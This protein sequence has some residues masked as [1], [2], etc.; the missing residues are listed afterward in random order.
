M[1]LEQKALAEEK[2]MARAESKFRRG[3]AIYEEGCDR[4]WQYSPEQLGWD[5]AQTMKQLKISFLAKAREDFGEDF[6]A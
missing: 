2:A 3:M 1:N 6:G 5:A 4:P